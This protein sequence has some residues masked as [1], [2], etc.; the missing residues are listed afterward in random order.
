[1]A[2]G[3]K[4]L[5]GQHEPSFMAN[6]DKRHAPLV[7]IQGGLMKAEQPVYL[8]GEFWRNRGMENSYD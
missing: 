4:I 1:M 5:S 6:T 7:N 2:M 8:T 3:D